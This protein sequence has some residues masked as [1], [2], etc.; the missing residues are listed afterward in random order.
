VFNALRE[1]GTVFEGVRLRVTKRIVSG[2]STVSKA[3]LRME[4]RGVELERIVICCR[5]P[6]EVEDLIAGAKVVFPECEIQVL[7]SRRE[8]IGKGL[9]APKPSIPQ[10]DEKTNEKCL[11]Y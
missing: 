9:P 11:E 7:S 4:R 3:T 6:E 5:C 8:R 2:G 1:T 10:H